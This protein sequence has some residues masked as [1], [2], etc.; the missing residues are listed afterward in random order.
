MRVPKE[1][2][3]AGSPRGGPKR[4]V[5]NGGSKWLSPTKGA[6]KGSPRGSPKIG[7]SDPARCLASGVSQMGRPKRPQSG[8]WRR[9]TKRAYQD[10]LSMGIPV[11]NN[12]VACQVGISMRHTK[13][14]IPRA[15]LRWQSEGAY[16]GAIPRGAFHRHS[17]GY[18][19]GVTMG[20]IRSGAHKGSP[21]MLVPKRGPSREV[22]R[23]GSPKVSPMGVHWG[24]CSG[25][26]VVGPLGCHLGIVPLSFYPGGV[27]W[28]G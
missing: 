8:K 28:K 3:T 17:K 22:P 23:G 24:G 19:E 15:I 26:F 13:R 4:W 9:H 25:D 12:E 7:T 6:R 16:H 2:P 20:W 14:S 5:H 27:P 18:T 10:G 1:D 21:P 11:G